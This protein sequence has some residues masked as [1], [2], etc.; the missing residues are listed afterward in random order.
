MAAAIFFSS[1][2]FRRQRKKKE[3]NYGRHCVLHCVC[4]CAPA[5]FVVGAQ[6]EWCATQVVCRWDTWCVLFPE[7]LKMEEKEE[8]RD[9][10]IFRVVGVHRYRRSDDIYLCSVK[11]LDI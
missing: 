4:G 3:R 10:K 2:A 7:I 8:E 1:L 5:S 9:M 6:S 11:R